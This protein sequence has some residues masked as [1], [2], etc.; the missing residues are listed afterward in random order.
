M[1]AQAENSKADENCLPDNSSTKSAAGKSVEQ[2]CSLLMAKLEKSQKLK[3]LS[4]FLLFFHTTFHPK[5]STKTKKYF[6][7][8]SKKKKISFEVLKIYPNKSR[9]GS[10]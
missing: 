3:F 1:A 10:V 5:I 4:F 6:S 8:T 7:A 2:F 9:R